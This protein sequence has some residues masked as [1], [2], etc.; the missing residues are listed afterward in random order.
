[1]AAVRAVVQLGLVALVITAVLGHLVWS[2]LFAVF[3]F[4]VAVVTSSRRVGA[5]ASWP[6]VAVAM[7]CGVAP[8]LAVIFASGAVPWNGASLVPMAGIVIG[9][10]MSAHSLAGRRAFAALRDEHGEYEAALALGLSG[11]TRSPR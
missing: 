7:G 8:V 4:T 3:M 6:W 11:P 9:G 1:M 5:A 10:T 2:V